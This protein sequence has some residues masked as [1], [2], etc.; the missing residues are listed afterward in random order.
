M[1]VPAPA[2]VV[3]RL[4]PRVLLVSACLA[5]WGS[6]CA[7]SAKH[8]VLVPTPEA[9]I[10]ADRDFALYAHLHG[11]AN[12]F[13]DFAAPEALQLPMGEAPIRGREAIFQAMSDFPPGDLRW[14]PIGADLARSGE[15]GYTWG[16][17]EFHPRDASGV[18]GTRHGKYVTIWKR[19]PDGSW[20]FVVDTGN[21]SP[22]PR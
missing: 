22:P 11:V 14:H 21:A 13:R 3:N 1:K 17:Y 20:K 16:T 2:A 9:L 18:A 19:Q 8:H 6:G 4:F 15:L 12:A 7:T 10:T 5:L